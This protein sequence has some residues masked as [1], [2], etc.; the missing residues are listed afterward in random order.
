MVRGIEGNEMSTKRATA[1]QKPSSTPSQPQKTQ[2]TLF[3]FFQKQAPKES[4]ITAV[5]SS[6]ATAPTQRSK[7]AASFDAGLTPAPSS[8]PI[9]SPS[10]SQSAAKGGVTRDDQENG[11][12]SPISSPGESGPADALGKGAVNDKVSGSPS[13]KVSRIVVSCWIQPDLNIL[14]RARV[15]LSRDSSLR[16]G[17]DIAQAKKSINYAESDES[18][19]DEVFQPVSVNTG[20]KRPSKRRRVIMEDSD[21]EFE[22]DDATVQAFED[23]GILIRFSTTTK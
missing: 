22:M 23:Q 5:S 12:P 8:D 18:G 15:A 1:S 9:A 21:D 6:P 13:R 2:R 11:L 7:A 17:S 3:G 16:I 19:E 20:S 4:S 10:P 14:P